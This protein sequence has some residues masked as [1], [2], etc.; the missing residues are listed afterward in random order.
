[1]RSLRFRLLV[2]FLVLVG[3]VGGATLAVIER[4]LAD[5]LVAQLGARMTKQGYAVAAW[6]DTAP[7]AAP[8]AARLGAVTDARVTIVGANGL[9]VADSLDAATV[10]RP[11]GEAIEVADARHGQVGH[12]V[13]RVVEDGALQYL[14]AVPTPHGDVVRLAVPLDDVLATRARMRDRLLVAAAF[15][16]AG[17][18]ALSWLFIRTLTRPLQVMTQTAKRLAAGDYDTPPDAAEGGE[19][20]V[21][22]RA[23]GHMAGE[24]RARID[25]LTQ[26]RDL[27]STVF[28]GLAE[29]VVIVGRDGRA[30]LANDATRPLVG[31]T[32]AELPASLRE[33]VARA[34]ADAELTLA[35]R[36]V[37]ASARPL[38]TA[39]GATPG[40]AA[41]VVLS[42][43]TRLR[44]LE[45]VR[46]EFL[47]NAA[48]ELRTPVTAISG[49]AETLLA[50]GVDPDT[51]QEF[52]AT[53]HRNAQRIAAL[54]SD[55]LVLDSLE[56][57]GAAVGERVSVPLAEVAQHA[58]ATARGVTPEADITVDI[59]ESLAV[60]GTRDGV[61]HVVQ[62]LVDNAVAHG[63]GTP[64]SVAAAATGPRVRLTVTDGGPGIPA[65]MESSVF[66]RFTRIGGG[67]GA[68]LGLA[69]VKSQ[70]EAMGGRVWVEPA[71]PGARFVVELDGG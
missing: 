64:I 23:M 50:G 44:A 63:A 25:E 49:Y 11:V 43:V 3:L 4:A 67:E 27:L 38:P 45:A 17:C 21:L 29:G 13:R 10:G 5:D 32:G 40:P 39:D 65:D 59:A 42:D 47:S 34:P 9:V 1:V 7:L 8:D 31:G 57:R 60:L 18:L 22:S 62:N 58:A 51:S 28:A 53:I 36:A 69:I 24:I 48:H 52:L 46:R 26:Q 37:R 71:S 70:V 35:G 20:G 56:G 33:L 54:V 30:L 2:A 15:G 16:F 41:I 19:L 12:A 61:D 14:V 66:E 68:G 6:I 55:L